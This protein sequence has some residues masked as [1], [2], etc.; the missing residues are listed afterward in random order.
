MKTHFFEIQIEITNECL[1]NCKHC[2]SLQIRFS[3][4]RG[5][6]DEDLINFISL[7][8]TH[9]HIIFTGGD[10]VLYPTLFSLCEEIRRGNRKVSFGLYTTGNRE[11]GIAIDESYAMKMRENGINE[12]YFSI[13]HSLSDRHDQWT[14]VVGSFANTVKSVR[15]VK[16]VGI[17]PKAHIVIERENYREISE[18]MNFCRAIGIEEVRFLKLVSN[19]AANECWDEISITEE[20]QGNIVKNLLKN[21]VSSN[22][23][24]TISGYPQYLPCRPF[25]DA[26]GCQAGNHLLYIAFN[27][28]VYPC[29]GY[30]DYKIGNILDTVKMQEYLNSKKANV[31]YSSKCL[32]KLVKDIS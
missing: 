4:E 5:Y 28:D 31:E 18:I 29:A 26:I 22:I 17:I 8:E 12:C 30:R 1:L 13:Y 23:K 19:G 14:N 3:N 15:S 27:G 25:D 10:P 11:N 2:S 20:E 7:F 24:Y 6:T 16:N 21:R 32:G 9:I